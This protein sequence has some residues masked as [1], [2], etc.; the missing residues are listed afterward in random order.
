METCLLSLHLKYSILFDFQRGK[1]LDHSK[2]YGVAEIEVLAGYFYQNLEDKLK[3]GQTEE[4]LYK[5]KTFKYNLL[6]LQKEVPPELFRPVG[7][8]KDGTKK[9]ISKT[10]TEWL[11]EEMLS[12]Q[13]TYIHL[14]PNLLQL[15]EVSYALPCL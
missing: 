8:G 12:L 14:C 4:L 6:N 5:W 2:E 11:L 9:L 15:A 3:K 1:K 13:S 10:P 7:T